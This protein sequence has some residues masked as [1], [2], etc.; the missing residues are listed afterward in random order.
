M[1]LNTCR[2]CQSHIE[3]DNNFD[4]IIVCPSCG[5]TESKNNKSLFLDFLSSSVGFLII[6][7]GL[8]F[9]LFAIKKWD[10]FVMKALPLQFR[11]AIGTA[12]TGEHFKLVEICESRKNLSCVEKYTDKIMQQQPENIE[13]LRIKAHNQ[14]IHKEFEAAF[15]NYKLYSELQGDNPDAFYELGKLYI[16]NND[17]KMAIQSFETSINAKP[18]TLQITVLENYVKALI[19]DQNYQKAYDTI[20]YVQENSRKSLF[21]MNTDFE[22]LEP[23]VKDNKRSRKRVTRT[24][25]KERQQRA[26]VLPPKKAS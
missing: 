23:L 5:H 22:K 26:K 11:S 20:K 18:D 10:T 9:S 16:Q 17:V 12:N 25:A 14:F 2:V 13:A 21:F 19:A 7:T 6:T 24:R 8:V 3:G 4:G 15:Q 1:G